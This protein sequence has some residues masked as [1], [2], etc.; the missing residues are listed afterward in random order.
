MCSSVAQRS[1]IVRC[2]L[3]NL[4]LSQMK[5][6]V[7]CL[8]RS[9][10]R[11]LRVEGEGYRQFVLLLGGREE[12][13]NKKRG[14]TFILV[15]SCMHAV[16]RQNAKLICHHFGY[17][18]QDKD[19]ETFRLFWA[20]QGTLHV[21]TPRIFLCIE[22]FEEVSISVL[23]STK[24]MCIVVRIN[25]FVHMTWVYKTEWAYSKRHGTVH[26]SKCKSIDKLSYKHEK[27]MPEHIGRR[28]HWD[29]LS[30][31]RTSPSSGRLFVNPSDISST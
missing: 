18:E 7:C 14:D 31:H 24:A 28:K 21:T 2:S 19:G 1:C 17:R 4:L 6:V 9:G 30:R 20:H 3:T 22:V 15:L 29:D 11:K 5:S 13:G 10:M 16:T 25:R 23:E 12:R 27:V 8:N 26:L